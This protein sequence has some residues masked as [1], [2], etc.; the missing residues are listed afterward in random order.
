MQYYDLSDPTQIMQNGDVTQHFAYVCDVFHQC[1]PKLHANQ[2]RVNFIS[3]T[4]PS[5]D[6]RRGS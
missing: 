3:C 1:H 6:K 5:L 2:G 4:L